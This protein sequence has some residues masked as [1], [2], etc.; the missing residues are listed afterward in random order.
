VPEERRARQADRLVTIRLRMTMCGAV[1]RAHATLVNLTKSLLMIARRNFRYLQT[2]AL[3][4]LT[5][6]CRMES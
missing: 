6:N 3:S 4:L 1:M 2:G 5:I